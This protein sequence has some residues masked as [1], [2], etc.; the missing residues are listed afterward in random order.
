VPPIPIPY[1]KRLVGL[2]FVGPWLEGEVLS[3]DGWTGR[4]EMTELVQDAPPAR[5]AMLPPASLRLRLRRW[6]PVPAAAT[7]TGW[8][9]RACPAWLGRASA[10]WDEVHSK[11]QGVPARRMGVAAQGEVLLDGLEPGSWA[12]AV[13]S[14]GGLI[15]DRRTVDAASGVQVDLGDWTLPASGA[16]EVRARACGR[17]PAIGAVRLRYAADEMPR[18][19]RLAPERGVPDRASLRLDHVPAGSA[20]LMPCQIEST[21]PSAG[22]RPELAVVIEPDT[23]RV[24]ELLCPH[25][26]E[27]WFLEAPASGQVPF[28]TMTSEHL[29]TDR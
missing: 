10:A 7:W 1:D 28:S 25:C 21:L 6:S 8:H 26:H 3:A 22:E 14:P 20:W 4:L 18:A 15:V 9:V 19:I 2:R 27:S 12:L 24:V 29:T 17:H 16:L 13:E 5:V 11:R 23:V